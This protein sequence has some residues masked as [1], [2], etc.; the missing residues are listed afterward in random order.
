MCNI[1]VTQVPVNRKGSANITG[2]I[3]V[4]DI[5]KFMSAGGLTYYCTIVEDTG[6][7]TYNVRYLGDNIPMY[8]TGSLSGAITKNPPY[9]KDAVDMWGLY[10][11][12]YDATQTN[13]NISRITT[14][15]SNNGTDVWS[16]R[17]IKT[18]LGADINIEYEGDTYSQSVLNKHKSLIIT[19]G[20]LQNNNSSLLL[21][22]NTPT[23]DYLS[24][25]LRVGDKISPVLLFKS[26]YGYNSRNYVIS[27]LC[28]ILNINNNQVTIT[29]P[30]ISILS[31]PLGGGHYNTPPSF[32]YTLLTGNMQTSSPS[33]NYGGGTRVKNVIVD[34]LQ[35]NIRKTNYNYSMPNFAGASN[36]ISSGVTSYEPVSMDNDDL[37]SHLSS[38][39]DADVIQAYRKLLHQDM[40]D[41]LTLSRVVPAPGVTYQ[42]VTVKD[43]SV[44]NGQDIPESGA[45]LYQYRTFNKGMVGIDEYQYHPYDGYYYGRNLSI[46]DYTS[47]VGNLIRTVQYDVNGNKLMESVNHFLND[48]MVDKPFSY[49]ASNYEARLAPY[50]YQGLI[51]ERYVDPRSIDFGDGNGWT[52]MYVS[53]GMDKYPIIPTGTTTIDY[54]NGTTVDQQNLGF[55]FYSGEITKTLTVDSYGNRF[56]TEVTPA[57][58][59]FPMMGLKVYDGLMY[60][61]INNTPLPIHKNMLTQQASTYSYK[62]DGNNNKLSVLSATA[63][64]WASNIPI[65]DPDGNLT[66]DGQSYIWR[67]QANYVWSFPGTTADN[68]TPYN[69]FTDFYLNPAISYWKKNGEVTLYDVYSNGLEGTDINSNYAA[70]RMGYNNSKVV[71]SGGSANFNELAYS[72]AEDGFKNSTSSVS[73]V[74]PGNGSISNSVAHTGINSLIV[75]GGGQGFSYTVPLSK[76]SSN[77]KDYSVAVWVKPTSNNQG[78]ASLYYQVGNQAQHIPVLNYSKQAAGW[79]LLEIHIPKTDIAAAGGSGNLIVGCR[80]SGSADLYFDDFRFQPLNASSTAY[81]YDLKT[82]ELNYVLGNNNLYVRYEY[83]AAGRLVNTYKEV[84]GK[85]TVPLIKSVAYHYGKTH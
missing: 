81:V 59:Q 2:Y 12:D 70:T 69:A 10:K 49:Q 84:L 68:M 48:D 47:Q 72:G 73:Y 43:Y 66:T 9:N 51:Q 55:D 76:L 39:D 40:F 31:T 7:G 11:S 78:D 41:L 63:Q 8:V 52:A 19:S 61:L 60:D 74:S 6:Y 54:K 15:V 32:V 35:G 85:S 38:T 45:T 75:S 13:E 37:Y 77:P 79:Y 26:T 5:L 20:S 80:N 83:D 30:D 27:G 23:N 14:N 82:D 50:F 25:I 3:K 71:I 29:S 22:V 4:G 28:T 64:T 56:L 53:S 67:M 34:D 21:N 24:S 46:K 44:I 58:H 16:L 42:Y 36:I 33:V 65:I 17:K 62:V 57:Y 1:T 18:N